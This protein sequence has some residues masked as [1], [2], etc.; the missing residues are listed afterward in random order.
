LTDK[1]RRPFLKILVF[2]YSIKIRKDPILA[3]PKSQKTGFLAGFFKTKN[4]K[5]NLPPRRGE[6]FFQKS[7]FFMRKSL[8]CVQKRFFQG[9]I[10]CNSSRSAKNQKAPA[11]KTQERT[12]N[13]GAYNW[14]LYRDHILI[15]DAASPK[16]ILKMSYALFFS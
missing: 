9:R 7:A 1:G 5:P 15:L 16:K 12:N 6:I 4:Q 11:G 14:A 2:L 10:F 8:F 3:T 13:F